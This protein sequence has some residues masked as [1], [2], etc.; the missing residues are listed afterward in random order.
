[1]SHKKILRIA[2]SILLFLVLA[3]VV[4]ENRFKSF[5]FISYLPELFNLKS[6]KAVAQVSKIE[7]QIATANNQFGFKLFNQVFH[8]NQGQNVLIS[9]S[10]IALAL[11]MTYNGANGETKQAIASAL[12]LSQPEFLRL[13]D[14]NLGYQKLQQNWQ[15]AD[16]SVQLSLAHSLWA[17]EGIPFKH[18]FL[19]NNREYY[20]AQITNLNFT[21]SGTKNIINSWVKEASFGRIEDIAKTTNPKDVLLSIDAASFKGNWASQF[22]IQLTKSESFHLSD[23]FSKPHPLM[24]QTG[25][26]QYY[27]NKQFQ[28]VSLPFAD[29]R[30]SMYI[31]LPRESS[32]LA[33]FAEQLTLSNWQKWMRQ[34]HP[35]AGVLKIPRFQLE[36]EVSLNEALTNLGMG[37]VFQD[38]RAD[39]SAMTSQSV[40]IDRF[41]HK[42][43]VEVNEEGAKTTE[44]KMSNPTINVLDRANSFQMTVN[45]PFFF[46]IGDNQ[47]G[48]ILFMGS[49]IDPE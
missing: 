29:D 10:S 35:T 36:Y 3:G 27:D 25:E 34:F 44:I 22:D 8:P 4:T 21:N 9:P 38:D 6:S 17:K 15:Q 7:S 28:A 37:V 47:T 46:A 13:E 49:I 18:Q 16:S 48:T 39:F 31:F 40:F 26:Y 20:S 2:S 45:R 11:T 24:S 32:N 43:L 19:K 23:N 1:M 41:T 33:T 5:Q 30:F 12:N 14:V 42:A